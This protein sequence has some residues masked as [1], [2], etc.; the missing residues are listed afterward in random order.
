LLELTGVG[1]KTASWIVRDWL[2]TDEVAI[3][4]IHVI[5]AGQLFGLFNDE[6][7]VTKN[8]HSM[9]ERF[10]SFSNGIAIRT[11]E[12]DMLIWE[13]MRAVNNLAISI[14]AEQK[15]NSQKTSKIRKPGSRGIPSTLDA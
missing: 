11:S 13:E 14:L 12:L 15:A 8:Y 4:D 1:L 3:L 7:S 10:I 6:E 2:G 9:E 5:R